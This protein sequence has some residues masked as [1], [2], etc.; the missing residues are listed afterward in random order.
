MTLT[1]AVESYIKIKRSLGAVFSA[2][3]RILRSFARAFATVPL[4]AIERTACD[5][6]C[7]GSGPP[8]RFWERKH[9]A[10]RGF[11][12]F[13]IARGHLHSMPLADVASL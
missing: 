8:T 4:D 13:L 3:A 2:D 1:E 7:R 11:F 10:L 5:A 12:G 6:F 9:Q